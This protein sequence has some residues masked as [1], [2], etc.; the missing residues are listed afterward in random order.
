MEDRD[1]R[2]AYNAAV[3][4]LLATAKPIRGTTP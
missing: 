1:L 2:E 3:A 4:E